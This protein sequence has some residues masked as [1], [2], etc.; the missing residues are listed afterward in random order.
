MRTI[1]M[2]LVFV[3][4]ICYAKHCPDSRLEQAVIGG[5]T[6]DGDVRLRHKPLKFAQLR[7]FFSDGTTAWVGTTDKDGRFHITDLRPD[8]YRL[9]VRGWGRTS[10]RISPEAN[11]LPNGQTVFQTVHLMEDECIGVMAVTN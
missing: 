7:L 9:D 3:T 11:K 2:A 8:T 4:S 6:I 1:A 5:D 10:I